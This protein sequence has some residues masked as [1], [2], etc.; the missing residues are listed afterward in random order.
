M[1]IQTSLC[2]KNSMDIQLPSFVVAELY[3][4]ALV[5]IPE[6]KNITDAVENLAKD[7]EI[8]R[9][10]TGV[11]FLEK[12]FWLGDNQKKVALFVEDQTNVFLD[13]NALQFLTNILSACK[14]NLSDVALINVINTQHPFH[15]ITNYLNS[16]Y[17]VL[18]G[19]DTNKIAL[20]ENFELFQ[21]MTVD[22]ISI[23]AA[24]P[25]QDMMQ[26]TP[27]AKTLKAKL[28]NALKTMFGL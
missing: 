26:Q 7:T 25:L 18:F 4:D 5:I 9:T 28:W 11:S 23:A 3:K 21:N 13:G 19:I 10:K 14:L 20:K 17:A 12:K 22:S 6:T 27:D 1:S 15:E 8:N 24:P 2:K 16:R